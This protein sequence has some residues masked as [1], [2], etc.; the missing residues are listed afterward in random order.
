MQNEVVQKS[1]S[2]RKWH[3]FQGMFLLNYC[4]EDVCTFYSFYYNNLQ[5]MY[6]RIHSVDFVQPD[7]QLIWYFR[8]LKE[9]MTLYISFINLTKSFDLVN[10][11]SLFKI[12]QK[13][14]GCPPKHKSL[15]ESFHK[16]YVGYCTIRC[17][18]VWKF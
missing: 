13:T 4:G 3:Y 12:F 10:R 14:I 6:I 18:H 17:E 11:D 7:L 1:R 5:N 9:N 16:Q 8:K 15:I 2:V